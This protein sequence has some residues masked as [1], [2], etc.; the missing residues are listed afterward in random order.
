VEI[1]GNSGDG[2][3]ARVGDRSSIRNDDPLPPGTLAPLWQRALDVLANRP[4]DDALA[5]MLKV[6]EGSRVP[7]RDVAL[8]DSV[9]SRLIRWAR[10]PPIERARYAKAGR[11]DGWLMEVPTTKVIVA[12]A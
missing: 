1:T 12:V 8:I 9:G 3:V 5:D 4:R 6:R 10:S 7:F 2:T 11:V